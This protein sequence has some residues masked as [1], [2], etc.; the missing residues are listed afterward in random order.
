MRAVFT[1][2]AVQ[3]VVDLDLQLDASA[4]VEHRATII[5]R[6]EA[7]LADRQPSP[8][9]GLPESSTFLLALSR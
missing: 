5:E 2:M 3:V 7:L 1:D 6:V 4:L 8:W 9:L